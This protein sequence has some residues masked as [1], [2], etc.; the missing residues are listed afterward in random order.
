MYIVGMARHLLI[1]QTFINGD[2]YKNA[3]WITTDRVRLPPATSTCMMVPS[4]AFIKTQNG[5][6]QTKINFC[7][8]L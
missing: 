2:Y 7:M 5:P 4:Q 1:E 3:Q 8:C 6:D